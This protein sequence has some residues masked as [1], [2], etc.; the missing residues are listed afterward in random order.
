MHRINITRYSVNNSNT[1]RYGGFVTYWR[2][3]A[4]LIDM[5]KSAGIRRNIFVRIAKFCWFCLIKP[6]GTFYTSVTTYKGEYQTI[7]G[8][9]ENINLIKRRVHK[10]A[11]IPIF[12]TSTT[13]FSDEDITYLLK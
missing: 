6:F 9:F 12:W 8:R 11:R 2:L 3:Y 1:K 10:I 13:K 4:Q 5:V 7:N